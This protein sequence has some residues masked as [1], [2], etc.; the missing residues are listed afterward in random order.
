M[1]RY[2]QDKL[3]YGVTTLFISATML[4]DCVRYLGS[5]FLPALSVV[6]EPLRNVLYIG[7][8]LYIAYLFIRYGIGRFDALFTVLSAAAWGV[9]IALAPGILSFAA[10]AILLFYSRV[11]AGI[12]L[13]R[14]IRNYD[15]LARAL[16]FMLPVAVVYTGLA[17]F[18]SGNAYLTMS[19]NLL[20]V[21][22]FLMLY[23][24]RM[25]KVLMALAGTAS[26]LIAGLLGSRGA[27]LGG[28]AGLTLYV[29]ADAVRNAR[30]LTQARLLG[31][32]AVLTGIVCLFVFSE[33]V[34]TLLSEVFDTSRTLELLLS[35]NITS[36]SGRLTLYSR[37]TEA[38]DS[39]LFRPHG[40]LADR[41][42]ISGSRASYT[43]YPHSIVYEIVYQ[44]GLLLAIPLLGA[45]AFCLLRKAGHV[46][47]MSSTQLILLC[48]FVPITFVQL[49]VSSSYLISWLFGIAMGLVLASD[50]RPA[51]L[52]RC[53]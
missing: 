23:G 13:L 27:L 2:E 7:C 42:V 32:L 38:I 9:S 44:F 1:T 40:L 41:L 45:I 33:P 20:P 28:L 31:Y 3:Y 49:M 12:I 8:L 30:R 10:P 22:T 46:R 53:K 50:R 21:A 34:I 16:S 17:F 48:S 39:E 18:H 47:R 51:A 35:G 4:V 52:R 24:F 14:H 11:Y 43:S 6:V 37:I 15:R 26:F 5:L 19:Y 29:L 36:D 25:K